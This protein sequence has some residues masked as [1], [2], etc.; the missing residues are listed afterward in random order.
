[1]LN[2]VTILKTSSK[3]PIFPLNSMVLDK[4]SLSTTYIYKTA[5]LAPR[6]FSECLRQNVILKTK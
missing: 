3:T 2:Y 4:N 6:F 1:M 5:E